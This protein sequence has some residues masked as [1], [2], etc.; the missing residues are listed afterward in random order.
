MESMYIAGAE[1]TAEAVPVGR[2]H[3]VRETKVVEIA[4]VLRLG[5]VGGVEEVQNPVCR[6]LGGDRRSDHAG[7]LSE[8]A[9]S[10]GWRGG[11]ARHRDYGCVG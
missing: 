7:K 3:A 6:V 4:L 9:G 11:L 1:P 2:E 10:G 8:S 5:V